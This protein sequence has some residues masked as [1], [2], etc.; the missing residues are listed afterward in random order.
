MNL[1]QQLSASYLSSLDGAETAMEQTHNMRTPYE[2]HDG[3]LGGRRR[4]EN[5]GRRERREL[6][7]RL[8][9]ALPLLW[10]KL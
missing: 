4:D 8:Y 3:V 1:P 9:L 7:L 6:A 2:R 10:D 5:L